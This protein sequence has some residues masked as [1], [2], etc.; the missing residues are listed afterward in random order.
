MNESQTD[1]PM[2]KQ[3]KER[4]HGRK[5]HEGGAGSQRTKNIG[6]IVRQIKS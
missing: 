1:R 3:V 5:N 4:I 2:M 6:Q